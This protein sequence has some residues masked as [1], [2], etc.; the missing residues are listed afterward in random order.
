MD[1]TVAEKAKGTSFSLVFKF[2]WPSWSL[3][4]GHFTVSSFTHIG[5]DGCMS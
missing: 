5:D 3:T 1:L 2:E 4:L